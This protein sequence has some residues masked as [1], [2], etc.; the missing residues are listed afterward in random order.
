[1]WM[2]A[3][4]WGEWKF[5]KEMCMKRRQRIFV[6]STQY[7]LGD[8]IAFYVWKQMWK[9]K[10]INFVENKKYVKS[11]GI[12]KLKCWR[13]DFLLCF[14]FKKFGHYLSKVHAKCSKFLFLSMLDPV[15]PSDVLLLSFLLLI[16][17]PFTVIQMKQSFSGAKLKTNQ[18]S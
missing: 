14:H 6:R 5:S 2:R 12:I 4:K 8:R 9:K 1:M 15:F 18:W 13:C 17:C 16:F 3:R 7:L 10:H 11:R